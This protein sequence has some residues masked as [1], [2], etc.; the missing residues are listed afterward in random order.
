[1][2]EEWR[3]F[4]CTIGDDQAFIFVDVG[5]RETIDDEAPTKLARLRLR[6][7]DPHENGLPKEAESEQAKALEDRLEEIVRQRESWYVGRVTSAGHRHFF[8][9]TGAAE[10]VWS[11]IAATLARDFDYRID[12]AFETDPEHRGYWDH[13]YPTADDWQVIKD[14]M[15]L[16]NLEE[17]GDDGTAVRQV[18]HWAY[19]DSYEKALSFLAWVKLN[20]FESE[21]TK[22]HKTDGG[23]YSIKFHHQT[24]LLLQTITGHTLKLRCKAEELGGEYDGWGTSIEIPEG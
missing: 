15:V 4:P 24:D 2:S 22:P 10:G 14:M 16:E 23:E 18:D 11:D 21:D 6:Y 9:Y 17:H 19:F 1:M 5:I 7:K 20:R 3:Y 12:L 8:I 13:L